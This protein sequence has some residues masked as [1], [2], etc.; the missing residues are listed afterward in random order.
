M[1]LSHSL[2]LQV[3][4]HLL[5]LVLR[6]LLVSVVV[7]LGE[8]R[9]Y[10]RVRVALPAYVGGYTMMEHFFSYSADSFDPQR[11]VC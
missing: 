10:L 8:D 2:L 5:M 7:V 11:L 9:S 6:Q 3:V 1:A 4:P